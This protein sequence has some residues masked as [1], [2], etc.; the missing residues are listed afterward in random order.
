MTQ[1]GLGATVETEE[2]AELKATHRHYKGGL[3]RV[4]SDDV[5]HTETN[6][7]LVVYEHLWPHEKSVKARPYD[8]FTATLEDGRRRFEPLPPVFW[9]HEY[10]PMFVDQG[11]EDRYVGGMRDVSKIVDVDFVKRTARSK[12]FLRFAVREDVGNSD[13]IPNISFYIVLESVGETH[14]FPIGHF[15]GIGID[16]L[17][18]Q[19]PDWEVLPQPQKEVI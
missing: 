4:I 19:F 16:R 13:C 7:R 15:S 1:I 8:N 14:P 10:R 9:L 5:S 11:V 6:E 18:A 3:Y 12:H 2:T 17:I